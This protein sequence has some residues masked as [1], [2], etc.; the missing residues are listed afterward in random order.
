MRRKPRESIL[1]VKDSL[2]RTLL[3]S[4]KTALHSCLCRDPRW[5]I[6]EQA[7]EESWKCGGLMTCRDGNHMNARE[8]AI[9]G[10]SPPDSCVIAG[11]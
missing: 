7:A 6:A 10:A 9:A 8:W 11:I 2:W 1:N 4:R 5:D 3:S